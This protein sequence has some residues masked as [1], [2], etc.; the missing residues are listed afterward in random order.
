[1]ARR[2][3]RPHRVDAVIQA[4]ATT[5][6]TAAREA[7]AAMTRHSLLIEPPYIATH[8]ARPSG[9]TQ[10]ICPAHSLVAQIGAG[11]AFMDTGDACDQLRELAEALRRNRE[12]T[13]KLA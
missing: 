2:S 6:P 9:K 8:I 3:E 10:V 1:M 12:R 5:R 4:T 7:A 13:V 11:V